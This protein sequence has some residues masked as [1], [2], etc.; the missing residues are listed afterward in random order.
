[1]EGRAASRGNGISGLTSGVRVLLEDQ[2]EAMM[3]ET[4]I[5]KPKFA[6]ESEEADWYPANPHYILQQLQIAETE[7]R[8]GHG[9]EAKRLGLT[10]STTI[11]LSQEDLAKARKQ[12]EKK[13][14]RYQT[15]LKMLLHEALAQA[16]QT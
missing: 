3:Q 12:A 7:G 8:L 2:G 4:L 5:K 16:E 9:T 10:A 14:L 13:G 1:M 15:Y 6:T 11:R